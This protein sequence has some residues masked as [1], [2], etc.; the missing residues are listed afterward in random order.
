MWS[1]DLGIWQVS[2]GGG[3][4]GIYS[5]KENVLLTNTASVFKHI[6][7]MEK[8]RFFF[9]DTNQKT[10]I[11]ILILSKHSQVWVRLIQQSTFWYATDED[12]LPGK[13]SVFAEKKKG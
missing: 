4:G 8:V 9:H 5:C 3:G 10:N 13:Y 7:I 12:N 2:S 11:T 6:N 1:L